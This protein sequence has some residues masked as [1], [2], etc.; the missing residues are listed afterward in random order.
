MHVPFFHGC[1]KFPFRFTLRN[2]FRRIKAGEVVADDLVKFVPLDALSTFIPTDD[3]SLR[4]EHE[5]CIV[6]HALD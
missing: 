4:A 6:F 2:G 1:P 5:N 3:P